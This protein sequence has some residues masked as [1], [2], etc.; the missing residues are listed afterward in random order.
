M[1][2]RVVKETNLSSVRLVGRGKVRDVYEVED[3]LL[4]VSTDRLSAFDVVLPD[5]IPHKGQ[6][7]NGLSAFWMDKTADMV[8][9]HLI[10]T[11][12]GEY[13][14]EVRGFADELEGRSMLVARAEP[15]PVECV[16]RGYIIGSGW[17]DYQRSGEICGIGLPKGLKQAEKLPEPIFT[18]STKA[19]I[20]DHD[21]NISFNRVKDLVGED[22]ARRLRDKTI[23]LY[24]HGSRWA[25][26]RGIIIADTKFEF[27]LVDGEMTLID[28]ALT[29]DS[30]RFWP[31]AQ[32]R[33]GISPPSLDKQF[34]RD[35]LEGLD[36]DKK[37]PAPSLP[38]DI[39]SK[40][41]EK[42]LQIYRILTGKDLEYR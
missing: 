2:L 10:T 23:E 3:K 21:E 34:V 1:G 41:E 42:Y 36:W 27:G 39:I 17:K 22:T 8:P 9:N 31:R 29:P 15:F 5:P 32:Y 4:I 6:V 14:E 35:Y 24:L 12:C 7:L 26:E 33:T 28:E 25:E 16:V 40:T 13:P 19:D 18:P 37:P 30:S 20:G 38:P 11:E